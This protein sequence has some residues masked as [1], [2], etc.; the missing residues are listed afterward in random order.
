MVAQ[1]GGFGRLFSC[2][3]KS[4]REER[5]GSLYVPRFSLSSRYSVGRERLCGILPP[6]ARTFGIGAAGYVG[7]GPNITAVLYAGLSHARMPVP[8]C[9]LRVVNVPVL[10]DMS[11]LTSIFNQIAFN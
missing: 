6:Y 2:P 11:G 8:A 1:K 3:P 5:R 10:A 4:T 7:R 9:G